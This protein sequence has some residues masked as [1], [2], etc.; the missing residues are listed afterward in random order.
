M[1]AAGIRHDFLNL[2]RG[3][4]TTTGQVAESARN[5][6]P[7]TPPPPSEPAPGRPFVPVP[8][9]CDDLVAPLASDAARLLVVEDN[10]DTA[11]L[12]E[13]ILEDRYEVTLAH[14]FEEAQRRLNGQPYDLFVF[15]I[16][17]G[18]PHTGLDLLRAA[19]TM[20]AYS[21]VPAIACTA[22]ASSTARRRELDLDAFDLIVRKPFEM[23]DLL[24]AVGWMLHR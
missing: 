20:A 7:L 18:G 3:F 23:D 1:H 5:G 24:G 8:L 14:S 13:M 17:L 2:A 16:H 9:P 22:Y 4:V 10:P 19:R 11:D 21:R 6:L 12:L 15:D